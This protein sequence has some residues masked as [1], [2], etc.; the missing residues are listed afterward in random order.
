MISGSSHNT[1]AAAAP[2]VPAP[3]TEAALP[4]G[5]PAPVLGS[6]NPCRHRMYS[7]SVLVAHALSKPNTK[8]GNTRFFII[9]NNRFAGFPAD[10]LILIFKHR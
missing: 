4:P 7:L 10:T 9:L 3:I 1:S 5:I 6:L 8:S 2:T